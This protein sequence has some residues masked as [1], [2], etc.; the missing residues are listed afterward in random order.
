VQFQAVSS[1]SEAPD[2]EASTLVLIGSS[3]HVI[4]R[5]S[6]RRHPNFWRLSTLEDSSPPPQ[7]PSSNNNIS[8]TSSTTTIYA[9]ARGASRIHRRHHLA[10]TSLISICL[11][12]F[13]RRKHAIR[14]G[15]CR[16]NNSIWAGESG[17]S[18]LWIASLTSCPHYSPSPHHIIAFFCR[19]PSSTSARVNT[20][21]E[22]QP[23]QQSSPF[24][25]VIKPHLHHLDLKNRINLESALHYGR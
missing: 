10:T 17:P 16:D 1:I 7:H 22:I 13:D 15:D 24:S 18:A 23:T 8:T 12:T 20:R 21:I 3:A 2:S 5:K 6:S 14:G 25:L 11:L 4:P 19:A 9:S